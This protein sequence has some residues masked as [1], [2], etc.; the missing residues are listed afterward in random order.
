MSEVS[1]SIG[2]Q[3]VGAFKKRLCRKNAFKQSYAVEGGNRLRV[4][5][6]AKNACVSA[7]LSHQGGRFQKHRQ[8]VDPIVGDPVRQDNDK[9]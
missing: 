2:R 6:R 4:G 5:E 3:R 8:P 1:F 9:I 7:L